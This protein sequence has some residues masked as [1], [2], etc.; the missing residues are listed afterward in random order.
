MEYGAISR[1]LLKEAPEKCSSKLPIVHREILRAGDLEADFPSVTIGHNLKIMDR[2][3]RVDRGQ[4][5]RGQ[6]IQAVGLRVICGD[7]V[8]MHG[9]ENR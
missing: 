9:H 5:P 1:A 4:E 3:P 7:R 2:E 6:Y 8:D